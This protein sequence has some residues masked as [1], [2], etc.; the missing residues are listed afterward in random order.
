MKMVLYYDYNRFHEVGEGTSILSG[1]Y[2]LDEI[3]K[4]GESRNWCPYYLICRAINHQVVVGRDDNGGD[5]LRGEGGGG[6]KW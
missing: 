3:K 2:H 6:C 1:L 5:D 4:W